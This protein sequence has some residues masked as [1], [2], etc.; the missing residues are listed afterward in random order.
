MSFFRFLSLKLSLLHYL[1]L[2]LS[3]SLSLSLFLLPRSLVSG[4]YIIVGK[5]EPHL[6]F[7][8]P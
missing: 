7:F 6:A 1:Y 3:L 2:S 5:N 4:C 8:S